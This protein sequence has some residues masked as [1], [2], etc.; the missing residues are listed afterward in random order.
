M[1]FSRSEPARRPRRTALILGA[2]W[3]ALATAPALDAA[4]Q[5]R[6]GEV[7][8]NLAAGRVVFCVT[9]DTIVVAA[10]E[11]GGEPGSHPPLIV[12]VRSDMVG[13]LL[14]AVEWK[15]GVNGKVL[16]LDAELPR[17]GLTGNR[18]S[19]QTA[20]PDDP[21]DIEVIGVG[22][23]EVVREAVSGI[24]HKLDL[25]PDEPLI[26]LL[27]ADYVQGYGPEI[28]SLRYRIQQQNLGNDYW[29]TRPMRPAYYQL[30][31]PEK[32]QPHTFVEAQ[33]PASA[34]QPGLLQRLKSTDPQLERV[35]RS[36]D[37]FNKAVTSVVQGES[38]KAVARP[39]GDFL[40]AALP[41]IAGSQASLAIGALSEEGRFQ[42]L[43]PPAERAPAPS[44]ARPQAP[45]APSLRGPTLA[46]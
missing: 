15:L 43:L 3:A 44:D 7:V 11:E 46:R 30:Y 1:S 9:R 29:T 2:L 31:P 32:G 26:E 23:L 41:I 20:F 5:E 39:V 18:P 12:P 8:A 25:A 6:G 36:S 40:R 45:G 21:T 16:R 38:Q 28:W 34:L 35:R 13:V 42:W 37:E 24:H 10:V 22:L 27:L 17:L 19:A 33:Y 14:G 4:P